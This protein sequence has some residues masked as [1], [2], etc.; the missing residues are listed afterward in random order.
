MR[1]SIKGL[2]TNKHWIFH[3]DVLKH[4]I[5][6]FKFSR[7]TL[8]AMRKR[9][10]ALVCLLCAISLTLLFLYWMGY[11]PFY[12][13]ATISVICSNPE[14]WVGRKVQVQGTLE[15]P[16]MHTPEEVPSYSYMLEEPQTGK[17]IGIA[18]KEHI[19]ISPWEDQNVTIVGLV[20]K[21]FTGPLRVRTVY[22]IE[23]EI[24]EPIQ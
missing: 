5:I 9:E 18:F 15:G 4:R 10:T 1:A 3:K 8:M 7:V 24:I 6:Y 12:K 21:G 11:P 16:H 19:D 13:A 14:F 17:S 22:Y 23:A 20:R 2:C